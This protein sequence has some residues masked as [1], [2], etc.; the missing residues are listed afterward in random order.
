M[1][2][3]GY[4]DRM[5]SPSD[6]VSMAMIIEAS[7]PVSSIRAEVNGMGASVQVSMANAIA[8]GRRF[9]SVHG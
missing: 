5:T 4:D 7:L 6:Y 2:R 1:K 3:R 8:T 9:S